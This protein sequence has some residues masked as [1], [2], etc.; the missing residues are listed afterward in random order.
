MSE[1]I[2]RDV[3]LISGEHIM[4][5]IEHKLDWLE[6]HGIAPKVL[7]LGHIAYYTFKLHLME[8][9]DDGVEK[10]RDTGNT[11][12]K[13]YKGMKVYDAGIYGENAVFDKENDQTIEVYGEPRQAIQ[14]PDSGSNGS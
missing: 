10:I 11:I 14:P 9:M 5:T 13:E 4:E 3:H 1:G 8:V 7:M 2:K 12:I 6:R